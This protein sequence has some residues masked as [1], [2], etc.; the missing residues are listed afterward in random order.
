MK[1]EIIGALA[2]TFLTFTGG[3]SAQSPI[4]HR[5][6]G[7]A[8]HG[9][10]QAL[11]HSYES[12][13]RHLQDALD[14][15]NA[16]L[17]EPKTAK[18]HK[19]INDSLSRMR[20]LKADYYKSRDHKHVQAFLAEYKKTKFKLKPFTDA[21][22][23][24]IEKPLDVLE[25]FEEYESETLVVNWTEVDAMMATT[26]KLIFEQ[27]EAESM[28]ETIKQNSEN[29]LAQRQAQGEPLSIA[30]YDEADLKAVELYFNGN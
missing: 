26:K 27:A 21:L 25:L 3:A 28:F 6:Q 14:A 8:S 22:A 20:Q 24:V 15:I 19:E 30:L 1:K 13:K 2:L 10:T 17:A 5:A 9:I 4:I 11:P 7:P 12:L 18:L 16:K 23:P 29:V